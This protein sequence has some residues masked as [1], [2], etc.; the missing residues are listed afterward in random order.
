MLQSEH[1][2]SNIGVDTAENR[3]RR[4]MRKGTL[5]RSRMVIYRGHALACTAF[6]LVPRLRP[7]KL[8]R[9]DRCDGPRG[10][11]HLVAQAEEELAAAAAL[12]AAG[13]PSDVSAFQ[14]SGV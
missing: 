11:C 14:R 3:P 12:P 1:L 2:I 6:S 7:V 13:W 9:I 10:C 4:G 5:K 8:L